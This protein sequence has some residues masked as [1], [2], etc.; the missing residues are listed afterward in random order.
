MFERFSQKKSNDNE[1]IS[2]KAMLKLLR[3]AG[4]SVKRQANDIYE[5]IRKVEKYIGP[6]KKL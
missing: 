6:S 3:K 2:V 4:A 5:T 1:V